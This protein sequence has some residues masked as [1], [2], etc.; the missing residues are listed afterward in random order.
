MRKTAA[1]LL[2]IMMICALLGGCWN[3]RSLGE[4][5]ITSGVAVDRDPNTGLYHLSFEIVD[6][7][8]PVKEKGIQARLIESDGVTL[9]DAVRNAKKRIVN[10]VFFGHMKLVVL[11]EDLV[12]NTDMS[13]LIDFFLRDA[14]CRETMCVAVSREATA[15][16]L[17]TI[18]GIGA[19]MVAYEIQKIIEEDQKVTAST[20]NAEIFEMYNILN[21]EGIELALPAFHNTVNDGEPASEADGIAV[22]KGERFVGYL[23]PQESKSFL[24]VT[25]QL[26]GG[27]ITCSSKSADGPIDTTLEISDNKTKLSFDNKDGQI[28][29]NIETETDTFL[30]ES[31][32]PLDALDTETIKTIEMNAS[33]RVMQN[34]CETIDKVRKDYNSDIFGFGNL[35]YRQDPNLW[36]SLADRWDEIFPELTVNVQ[37]KVNIVNSASLKKS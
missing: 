9:F 14:E 1:C 28:T 18:Y 16:D 3:Y 7:S 27:V 12:R 20:S 4:M 2:M 36:R 32:E 23:T 34:I 22:F 10:K 6:L 26:H 24:F 33:Q 17:L 19:P 30:N 25:N 37:C 31:N 29:I 8:G 11:S 35:I 21:G 13:T 5:A 15:K